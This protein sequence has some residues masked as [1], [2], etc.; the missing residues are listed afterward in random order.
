M[1]DDMPFMSV[2]IATLNEEAHIGKLLDSFSMQTYPKDRFEVLLF[3]GMSTDSTVHIAREYEKRLNLVILENPRRR[4][5]F[6]FNEGIKIAKGELYMILGA[7]SSIDEKF[8]ERHYES[9]NKISEQHDNVAGVGGIHLQKKGKTLMSRMGYLF[10]SSPLSGASFERFNRQNGFKDTISFGLYK[11]SVLQE[12]G[13]FDEGLITGQD[14]EINARIRRKGY[15]LYQDASI[16]SEYSIRP[17]MVLFIKQVFR[18]AVARGVFFRM[19]YYN[20]TW[21]IPSMLILYE[22]AALALFFI[23][24]SAIVL[25][26][27]LAYII[28]LFIGGLYSLASRKDILAIFLPFLLYAAHHAA[29]LGFIK[30]VVVGKDVFNEKN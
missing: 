29:G 28:I 14:Y 2:V 25:Y 4:Q 12:V 3:D 24:G 15:L 20:M 22:I 16:I 23:T 30:G 10:F 11:K 21:T 13:G 17:N 6:A 18:Y 19:K 9:F 8:L 27:L 5:V 7:H 1:N 26:P